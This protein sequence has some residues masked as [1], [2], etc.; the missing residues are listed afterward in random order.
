MADLSIEDISL[1]QGLASLAP[2]LWTD[3]A[4]LNPAEVCRRAGVRYDPDEGYRLPY[5]GADHLIHPQRRTITAGPDVRPPGFQS[6]M[7]M[8]NYLIHAREDGLSGRLVTARELEGGALFF[9]GPHTLLTEP[10]LRRFSRDGR[11]FLKRAHKW[12]AT[13]TGGGDAAFRLLALPKVLVGYTLYEED[14]EFPARLT[15]TF[16]AFTDRH[17]P[18]DCIF[19][20]INVMSGRLAD[21][22]GGEA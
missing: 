22:E 16:D 1:Y 9:Q 19:A 6:G 5:L 2:T 3:L 21:D 17:L 14:D 13:E 12:G 7:V 11:G 18:L 10:I 15:I 20:L 8:I 4:A